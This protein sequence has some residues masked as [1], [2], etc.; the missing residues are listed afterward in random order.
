MHL[1]ILLI[2]RSEEKHQNLKCLS[3]DGEIMSNFNFLFYILH[4]VYNESILSL[5]NKYILKT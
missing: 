5:T 4:I 3:L 1:Y 2:K